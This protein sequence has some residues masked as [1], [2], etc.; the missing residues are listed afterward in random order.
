MYSLRKATIN[1]LAELQQLFRETVE[2]I[3]IKEYNP[4]QISAW[5]AGVENDNR[6][7]E[8]LSS[9]YV[10][11]AEKDSLILG[12]ASLDHGNHLDFLYVHKD[13]QRKHIAQQLYTAITEEARGLKQTTLTADV[14]RTARPFFEKM[15]FNV[16][17][18][19]YVIRKGIRLVNFKMITVLP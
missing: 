11:V 12:F 7:Q 8:M 4:Q 3:C 1:D 9:H 16:L 13:F 19:Q 2:N 15:G 14:S 6:W 17:K 5:V 18:K 10:L